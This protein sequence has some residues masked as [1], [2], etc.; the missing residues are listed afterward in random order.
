MVV[1]VVFEVVELGEYFVGMGYLVLI[2]VVLV[3]G[4]V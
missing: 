2:M 4:D 1:D 3:V